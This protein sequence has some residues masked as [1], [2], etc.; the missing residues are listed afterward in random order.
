[1]QQNYLESIQ[2]QFAYYKLLG[3]K[4]IAQLSEAELLWQYSADSNSV[5]ILVNH[6]SGNMLSRWTDFLTTDGEKE[7][8]NRDQEF[9]QDSIKTKSDLLERWEKGWACLFAALEAINVDNFQQIIYIR[10]QG[11]T[12][13]DAFNRQLAHYAY[14]VGQMVFLGKLLKGAGWQN[15]SI[16]KGTSSAYNADKFKE[17][18]GLRHF[19]DEF[20]K[21]NL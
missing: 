9:E 15:L 13:V 12:I 1:M 7:W 21:N 14:H 20:L 4:T 8:R 3:D 10:N 17:E 19:T 6:L 18:K 11:H 5:A 2:K 16:P